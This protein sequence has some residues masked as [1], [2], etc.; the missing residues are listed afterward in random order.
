MPGIVANSLEQ[1][2]R[3]WGEI[4]LGSLGGLLAAVVGG[5]EVTRREVL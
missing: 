4:A 5:W 2:L 3:P 1:G